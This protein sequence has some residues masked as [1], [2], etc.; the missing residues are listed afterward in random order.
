MKWGILIIAAALLAGCVSGP[1]TLR[2][3]KATNIHLPQLDA[4]CA[5]QPTADVC[6]HAG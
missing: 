1:T 5:S 6:P 2:E 4:L 3:G